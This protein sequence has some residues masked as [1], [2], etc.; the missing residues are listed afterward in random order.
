MA[1]KHTAKCSHPGCKFVGDG[2]TAEGAKRV[3]DAHVRLIH[4]PVPGKGQAATQPKR[5]GRA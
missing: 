1:K 5:P 3:R 4:G 2:T